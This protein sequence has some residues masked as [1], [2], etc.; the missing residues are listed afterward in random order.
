MSC[1]A[2]CHYAVLL[3]WSAATLTS[4]DN[5]ASNFSIQVARRKV[6]TASDSFA[7]ECEDDRRVAG[8]GLDRTWQPPTKKRFTGRFKL[9]F[10]RWTV[11]RQ[12]NEYR[13]PCVLCSLQNS[14]RDQSHRRAVDEG[15]RDGPPELSGNCLQHFFIQVSPS[16]GWGEVFPERALA[17]GR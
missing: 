6:M 13:H 17:E 11:R 2:L 14:G 16:P 9:S 1:A 8:G 12:C 3:K 15:A 7:F 4:Y 5:I 10:L